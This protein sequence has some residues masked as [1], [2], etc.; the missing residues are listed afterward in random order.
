VEGNTFK[1][2]YF[3]IHDIAG[4]IELLGGKS[5]FEA[6][7][8]SIFSTSSEIIGENASGNI[9]GLIGQYAH[10]NEPSYHM[11]YLSN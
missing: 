8:D 9:T 2:S 10:G 4:H 3:T 6:S 7:L 1:W 11:A 5:A